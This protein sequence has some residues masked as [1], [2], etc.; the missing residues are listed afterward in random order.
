MANRFAVAVVSALGR[1][2]RLA[3][4]LPLA[5]ALALGLLSLPMGFV[6]D[7]HAQRSAVLGH[8]GGMT[9]GR[10]FDFT[11]GDRATTLELIANGTLPWWTDPDLRLSLFRPLSGALMMLDQRLFGGAA[12]WHHLHSVLWGIALVGAAA[13]VFRRLPGRAGFGLA[14][15]FFALD[16][17]HSVPVGWLANRNAVV[18]GTFGLLALAAHLRWRLD[19]WRLGAPLSGLCLVAALSAGEAGLG[20]ILYILAFEA[21]VPRAGRLRALLPSL[22]VLVPYAVA[23]RLGGFGAHRSGIYLDPLGDPVG[24]L[25]AAPQRLLALI[26]S[27]GLNF[28]VDLWMALPA[29]RLPLVALGG[30]TVA[31]FVWLVRAVRRELDEPRR[32]LHDFFLV[33]A[34]VSMAPSLATF[35]ASRMLLFPSIG[36]AAVLALA[37]R[38]L[39]HRGRHVLLALLLVVHGPIA[40][41]H[42]VGNLTFFA[43]VGQ[44]ATEAVASAEL[45][46]DVPGLRVIVLTT[47]DPATALYAPFMRVTA[48]ATPARHWWVLSQAATAHR[49]KRTGPA[50]LELETIGGR[51]LEGVF[52]QILRSPLH[53]LAQ[54]DRVAL[55]GG[56]VTVLELDE[57]LPTRVRL[58]LDEPLE[59]PDVRVL[60]WRDGGIRRARLPA[61][62][63]TVV[64]P[65]SPGI[66]ER[67]G[68][69]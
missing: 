40:V 63:E 11:P 41:F 1:S 61:I 12:S 14:L 16:E 19:G 10:L 46:A 54:G 9:V 52:E 34:L 49:L 51:F 55:A 53:P 37:G 38:S 28:P 31:L 57:G 33:G 43:E 65:R 47:G 45:E 25:V 30:L 69:Q 22:V 8:V 5:A 67:V 68:T 2:P 15:L 56:A 21:T 7:D 36:A 4:A 50:S 35:P 66:F 48:G 18:A 59:A 58:E 3:V 13:L 62:G 64:L 20:A 44:R 27:L 23:Y 39:W 26:G 32:R 6:M 17:S 24:L 29:T 60:E 42:W